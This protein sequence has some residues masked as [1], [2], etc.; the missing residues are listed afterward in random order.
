MQIRLSF[1]ILC[2]CLWGGQVDAAIIAAASCS[3]DDAVTAISSASIGDIV[4]V[5]AGECTWASNITVSQKITVQGAGTELT[6]ITGGGFTLGTSGARITGFGFTNSIINATGNSFRINH[7]KFTHSSWS[8]SIAITGSYAAT[9]P[10]DFIGVVDNCQFVNG[11][12]VATGTPAMFTDDAGNVQ[13]TLWTWPL[14]LGDNN[15]LYVEDCEFTST[16]TNNNSHDGN[17][18]GGYVARYNSYDTAGT[19]YTIEVHGVQG[20]N[21]ANRRWEV[22][23][24]T[25]S[26]STRTGP[27][28]IRGGTG[29]V[30]DNQTLGTFTQTH[31]VILDDQR[32]STAKTTSGKC[33][34]SSLWDGNVI[35]GYP[36]RDQIGRGPDTVKWNH[37]P[38]GAYTQPLVPAYLW[39]NRNSSNAIS[40]VVISDGGTGN[41]AANRDFYSESASFNGTSGVGV[42][43]LPARPATCTAGVGYWAT[44]QG[45]WN[46]TVGGEQGVLYKCTSTDTWEVYYTPYEYPHPLRGESTPDPVCSPTNRD[47]CD[48]TNCATTGEGYWYGGVCNATPESTPGTRSGAPRFGTG[49][50][51][52]FSGKVPVFVGAD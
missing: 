13:H 38:A 26:S 49:N 40:G 45:T 8:N 24:N 36:C 19:G 23:R 37:D 22:Y 14:G 33:D 30:F 48:D 44:D 4:T 5:P 52:A 18:G 50:P 15:S 32:S 25:V 46:K 3:R 29:V 12:V 35:G 20:A 6:K 31:A 7:C 27:Y 51:P 9:V 2:L 28:F 34:G 39:G 16:V 17:Y 47:L 21:R 1:L 11:R 42:G 10:S 43:P 41:V